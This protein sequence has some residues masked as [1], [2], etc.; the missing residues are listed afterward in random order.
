MTFSEILNSIT[1][2]S[3]LMITIFFYDP[4]PQETMG[5]NMYEKHESTE[6]V[7]DKLKLFGRSK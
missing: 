2:A 6:T 3:R 1:E 4:I 7:E 5:N